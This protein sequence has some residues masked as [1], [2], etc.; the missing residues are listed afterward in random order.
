VLDRTF[1]RWQRTGPWGVPLA[2]VSAV[3][4]LLA[5]L[6]LRPDPAPSQ[7]AQEATSAAPPGSASPAAASPPPALEDL[8]SLLGDASASAAAEEGTEG[9]PGLGA[10]EVT[11]NLEHAV[12]D[13]VFPCDGP[14]PDGDL[15]LWSCAHP[16]GGYAAEVVADDPLTVFSVTATARGLPE[17]DAEAFFAYVLGLCLEEEAALD[18]EAWASGNVPSGGQTFSDGLEVSVYGSEEARAM[19]VV[20]TDATLSTDRRAEAPNR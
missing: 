14:S 15:V 7:A 2:V 8:E 3:L 20:S 16:S 17:R 6:W 9:I 12:A 18:P 13:G 11:G 4:V 10:V 1:S 19:S 5:L